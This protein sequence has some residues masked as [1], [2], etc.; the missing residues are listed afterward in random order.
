MACWEKGNAVTMTHT[1]LSGSQSEELI[2][3]KAGNTR[4]YQYFRSTETVHLS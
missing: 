1:V 2:A 3:S 4:V